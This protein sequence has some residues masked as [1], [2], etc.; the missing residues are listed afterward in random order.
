MAGAVFKTYG[1]QINSIEAKDIYSVS[2]MPCTCKKFECDRP[3]MNSSGYRDVDVV[4]TTREL[5]YLIKDAG[6]NFDT[7][8]E[9]EFESP[10][11]VTLVLV[12]YLVFLVVL[13]KL[14]FVLA[15]KL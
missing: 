8:E 12:L 5:A 15:T 4:L 3:E 2:I 11:G 6:I 10:L 1:A 13:W 14:L 9:S 7:L